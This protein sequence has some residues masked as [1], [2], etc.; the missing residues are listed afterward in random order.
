MIDDNPFC[1]KL[2]LRR[3]EEFK[4][5]ERPQVSLHLL[6]KNGESCVGRLL[7]NVGP[8]I[9]EIVAVVNDTTDR[10]IPILREYAAARGPGNIAL[11]II[12]VTHETHPE[13]YILDVPETY[14]VGRSLAGESYAG[15][16][17]GVPILADWAGIRNL[18]WQRCTKPWIL[19]L[20]A[21]DV[22]QDPASIP[23]LCWS[24]MSNGVELG[25]SRYIYNLRDDG[26]SQS[27]S[28]RERLARNLPHIAW[29]GLT[30]ETLVGQQKTAH[31]DGNLVV[32]DMKDSQGKDIRIPGRCFKI[33]YHQAR[34]NDW[35]VPPRSLIYLAMESGSWN[36]DL[37]LAVLDQYLE[38]SLW[39]E[40]RAWACCLQGEIHE[41]REDYARSSEWYERALAEHP[42]SKSAFRLCRS[43][44]HECKWQECVDAFRIGVENKA[45]LQLLDSGPVY[46][47]MSKILV[48]AALDKLGRLDEAVAMCREALDAFPHNSNLALMLDALVKLSSRQEASSS[49]PSGT[50]S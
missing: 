36:P 43:R 42:G 33:L 44:F 28:F 32:H 39:P 13:L 8:Y 11:D 4:L 45:V 16:F 29:V 20:D 25:C 10:T 38:V 34:A 47:D 18:G 50:R 9:D 2:V 22:V 46:E 24:L 21:D 40:E 31:I 27:E 6:V 15:P 26:G 1:K 37:S 7:A 30:H 5:G 41:R 48:A 49:M 14:M 3:P 35:N 12:E 17:T 19:F 23:G